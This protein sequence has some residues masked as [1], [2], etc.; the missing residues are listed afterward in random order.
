VRACVLVDVCAC[1]CVCVHSSEPQEHH[2]YSHEVMG[3]VYIYSSPPNLIGG[4]G[5]REFVGCLRRG[6]VMSGVNIH[7]EGGKEVPGS[8]SLIPPQIESKQSR[9]LRCG[10]SNLI[11]G[12]FARPA[13]S[14]KTRQP[15]SQSWSLRHSPLSQPP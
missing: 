13:S 10:N 2:S 7:K 11:P 14:D 12:L 6:M 9:S 1:V 3:H 5:L 8:C 4:Y 15:Q